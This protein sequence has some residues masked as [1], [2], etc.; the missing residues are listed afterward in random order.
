LPLG[1]SFLSLWYAD[2]SNVIEQFSLENGAPLRTLLSLKAGSFASGPEGMLWLTV[3]S[4]PKS[5]C[6]KC[7]ESARVPDSCTSEVQRFDP[8]T[9]E[10][11]TE[12]SFPSSML[13]RAAEPSPNG[14]WLLMQVGGCTGSYMS[15]YLLAIN[16]KT[17]AEWTVGA[18]ATACHDLRDPAWSQN[19]SELVMPYGPSNLP[20]GTTQAPDHGAEG[21]SCLA[22]QPAGLAVVKAGSSSEFSPSALI[23]PTAGCSYESAVFDSEGILAVEGCS[24]D[25]PPFPYMPS[26]TSGQAYLVQLTATGELV[27]QLPLALG[28]NPGIV[29]SDP[30]TGTILVTDDQAGG[31]QDTNWREGDWVWEY[32]RGGL[33]LIKRYSIEPPVYAQAW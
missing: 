9:G 1:A 7:K 26:P 32:H 3:T 23:E 12:R 28:S 29:T 19:S 31:P 15:M 8:L 33:R 18:E 14:Q 16:L 6:E 17:G 5:Q 25:S 20:P 4:G 10:L 22:P 27:R 30:E 2:G 13:I 24:E 11:A 21:E